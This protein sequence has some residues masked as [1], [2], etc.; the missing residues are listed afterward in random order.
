MQ[1]EVLT[2]IL[3]G[4]PFPNKTRTQTA[5]HSRPFAGPDTLTALFSL[6]LTLYLA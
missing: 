5:V 6:V 1:A 4:A 3:P 2:F